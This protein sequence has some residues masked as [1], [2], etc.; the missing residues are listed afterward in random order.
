M[1]ILDEFSAMNGDQLVTSIRNLVQRGR[2]R[3]VVVVVT[4]Q[5]E[6]DMEAIYGKFKSGIIGQF[7]NAIYLGTGDTESAKA[8]AE[9]L[10]HCWNCH[11]EL[12]EALEKTRTALAGAHWRLGY[13]DDLIEQAK[14]TMKMAGDLGLPPGMGLPGI[15]G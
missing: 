11:D 8:N 7:R 4:D 1:N 15:G 12:V 13:Q 9:R 2:S 10:A 3:G 6:G 14:E 5:A